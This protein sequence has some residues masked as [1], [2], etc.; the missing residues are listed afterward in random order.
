M[1][2]R[3]LVLT[4]LFRII[5]WHVIKMSVLLSI[6]NLTVCG[7]FHIFLNAGVYEHLLFYLI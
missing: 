4:V 6:E 2:Y 3:R 7:V 5:K 1:H